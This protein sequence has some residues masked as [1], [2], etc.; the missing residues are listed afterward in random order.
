[1]FIF[2]LVSVVFN[3][4]VMVVGVVFK[5]VCCR[6]PLLCMLSPLFFCHITNILVVTT[7]RC[8]VSSYFLGR[9]LVLLVTSFLPSSCLWSF[10]CDHGWVFL[11]HR[12]GH[13]HLPVFM[14][15]LFLAINV[16]MVVLF[17]VLIASS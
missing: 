2:T 9:P 4:H 10:S 15:V 11:G 5:L 3:F 17:L 6:P 16:L 14:V 13:G 1:V 12:C 8:R 7:C